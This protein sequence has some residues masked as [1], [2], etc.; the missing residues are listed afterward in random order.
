MKTNL[1]H[2]IDFATMAHEGQVR[3]N[4]GVPYI[5]HPLKVLATFNELVYPYLLKKTNIDGIEMYQIA[6]V[7]HDVYEDTEYKNLDE[8]GCNDEWGYKDFVHA[9]VIGLTDTS[10]HLFPFTNRAERKV[11]DGVRMYGCSEET[12]LIKICDIMCNVGDYVREDP[13]Y[14]IIYIQE[15]QKYVKFLTK[16]SEHYK[17][18]I[19]TFLEEKLYEALKFKKGYVL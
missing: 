9:D 11:I 7:L 15:K 12:Q 3:K 16:L 8:M 14:A 17:V 6:C 19:N 4:S 13:D 5:Y 18:L 10:K 2:A 1:R